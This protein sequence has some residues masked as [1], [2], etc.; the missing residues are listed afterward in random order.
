MDCSLQG[1]SVQG[2]LQ[3]RI[4]EWVVILFSRG[5][6]QSRG[7]T[8]VS[9]FAGKFFTI[10]VT[11]EDHSSTRLLSC[12]LY[13][14]N[15]R[16]QGQKKLRACPVSQSKLGSTQVYLNPEPAMFYHL[17]PTIFQKISN[18]KY[19]NFTYLLLYLS[20]PSL[21]KYFCHHFPQSNTLCYKLHIISIKER[22]KN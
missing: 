11:R 2:I 16:D 21:P 22:I 20:S 15:I 8:P 6:S 17:W 18:P 14:R 1:S 9:H 3:T 5:S 10:W 4:L 7:Q 12:P 19:N 13:A